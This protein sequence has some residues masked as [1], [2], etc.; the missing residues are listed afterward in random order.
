MGEAEQVTSADL[1]QFFLFHM[2][3]GD[4]SVAVC[5]PEQPD[6]WILVFGTSEKNL[7]LSNFQYSASF[8]ALG[9]LLAK[10]LLRQVGTRYALTE[11]GMKLGKSISPALLRGLFGFA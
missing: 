11:E 4:G 9:R 5:R 7:A 1:E 6:W 2:A 8:R 3:A 10:K